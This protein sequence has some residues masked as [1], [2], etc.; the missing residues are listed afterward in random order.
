MTGIKC[1][2]GRHSN[3]PSY[4]N[5]SNLI[6]QMYEGTV[7]AFSKYTVYHVLIVTNM[8]ISIQQVLDGS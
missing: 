5:V 4:L 2:P 7:Q 1:S 8:P 6:V 3:L